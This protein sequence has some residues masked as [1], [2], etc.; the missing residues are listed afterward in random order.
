MNH[1]AILNARKGF[2]LFSIQEKIGLAEEGYPFA[3]VL[4]AGPLRRMHLC[5]V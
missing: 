1:F 5:H 4:G 2:Y 3:G